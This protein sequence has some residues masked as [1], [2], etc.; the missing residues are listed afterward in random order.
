MY[1]NKKISVIIPARG[2]SKSIPLKN[3]KEMAGKPLIFWVI[4]A[5]LNCSLINEVV[6]STDSNLIKKTVEELKNDKLKI[7]NRS[8]K[9]AT[10]TASTESAMLEFAESDDS[11][12][13]IILIQATSPFLQ[14]QH[15]TEGIKKYFKNKCD[16]LLSVVQQKRFIWKETNN[17]AKPVDCNSLSYPRR[18]ERKGFLVENGAFY[19]TSR[20]NLLKTKC[21]MSGKICIY[22]MP[23][24]TYFELDEP[25]DWIIME[26]LLKQ[27]ND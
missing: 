23:E 17:G 27:K 11:F 18:Q 24:E 15:L 21:R 25:S 4:E 7:I 2:G 19:I 22:E 6:V 1:K 8:K 26:K 9:T 16:G 20:K 12:E 13:H 3:I 5:A 10:D 14:T